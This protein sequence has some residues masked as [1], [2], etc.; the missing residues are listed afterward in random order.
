MTRIE[1]TSEDLRDLRVDRWERRRRAANNP[2]FAEPS[3]SQRCHDSL[4]SLP[5]LPSL[6]LLAIDADS[7][8]PCKHQSGVEAAGG[9]EP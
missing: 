5:S 7:V 4:P 9:S 2:N 8:E 3:V 6:Q 1:D